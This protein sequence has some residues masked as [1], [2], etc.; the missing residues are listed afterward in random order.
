[1]AMSLIFTILAVAVPEGS[2]PGVRQTTLRSNQSGTSLSLKRGSA[3][4]DAGELVDVFSG[5]EK[6]PETDYSQ[7][8]TERSFTGQL[9]T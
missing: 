8:S 2:A 4:W 1:M 6:L 3:I 5:R 7:A 9:R